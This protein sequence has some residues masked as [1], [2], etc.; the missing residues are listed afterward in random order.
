LRLENPLFSH[1]LFP[2]YF[3][4]LTWLALWL[5]YP[6]LAQWLPLH[7][8]SRQ[9]SGS[10][11]NQSGQR[12]DKAMKVA[13]Y[14]NFSGQCEEAFKTY[15]RVLGGKIVAIF[16]FG[17]SPMAAKY[18]EMAKKVMHAT[19][20]I[21]DQTIL[22]CDAPPEYFHKPEGSSV[23]LEADDVESAERIFRELAEGGDVKMPIQET[24]WAKRYG[25]LIDRFGT[26][27]MVNVSQPA[28]TPA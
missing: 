25:H 8:R 7:R 4:L 20:V 5:R 24:F 21:G 14:L 15:E 9:E 1:T 18:P 13:P 10:S 17:D 16:N 6:H 22:G 19:L 26:P 12:G 3:G 11:I 23:C 27:W 2:V 28:Y